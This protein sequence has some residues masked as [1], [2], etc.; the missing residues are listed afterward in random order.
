MNGAYAG[1]SWDMIM[2][3][4]FMLLD[5]WKTWNFIWIFT[6][7]LFGRGLGKGGQGTSLGW[8]LRKSRYLLFSLNLPTSAKSYFDKIV[9][10]HNK[11]A[12]QLNNDTIAEVNKTSGTISCVKK[13]S[14]NVL[15]SF[16]CFSLR[17]HS[18]RIISLTPE[19]INRSSHVKCM[20]MKRC[21][22][23]ATLPSGCNPKL[24]KCYIFLLNFKIFYSPMECAG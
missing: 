19:R 4:M 8:R 20:Y 22:K 13:A 14:Y 18:F 7:S 16:K 1:Q 24:N 3:F 23:E 21:Q 2:L 5:I 15:T 12:G 6:L 11:P 9:C 17:L 10:T